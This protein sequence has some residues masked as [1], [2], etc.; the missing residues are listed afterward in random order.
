MRRHSD[1]VSE[2]LAVQCYGVK[3]CPLKSRYFQSSVSINPIQ[4]LHICNLAGPDVVHHRDGKFS[5]GMHVFCPYIH[6][7]F[8]NSQFQT[9][10]KFPAGKLLNFIS[11]NMLNF[12]LPRI[13]L[14]TGYFFRVHAESP[15]LQS[16]APPVRW[17]VSRHDHGCPPGR[18]LPTNDRATGCNMQSIA[19]TA[20]HIAGMVT[21]YLSC[22]L[23]SRVDLSREKE[24]M[25]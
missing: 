22:R 11:N 23:K 15:P 14:V 7:N 10:G 21:R 18:G 9:T 19:T 25:S 12:F 3:T 2:M 1:M 24:N 4:A 17:R 16:Q 20:G 5:S 8:K 13:K 6:C